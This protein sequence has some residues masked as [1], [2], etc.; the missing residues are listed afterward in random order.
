[1][2]AVTLLIAAVASAL[3][4][5]LSP[6]YGLVVYMTALIW[7]P[8]NL[9]VMLGPANF[10]VSRIVILALYL[11][12]FLKKDTLKRLELIW[13]DRLV[14]IYFAVRILSGIPTSPDITKVIEYNSGVFFDRALPYFAVRIIITNKEQYLLLLKWLLWLSAPLAVIAFYESLTG[15]NLVDFG[16][17]ITY[18]EHRWG[19]YRACATFPHPIRLGVFFAMIGAM[20]AGL[21]KNMKENRL[22][23]VIGIG[24]T[25]VGVFSSMSSGSLLAMIAAILFIA[26]YRFRRYW[27]AAIIGIILMCSVVEIVSNRHFYDVID[28]FAFNTSTAWYRTRLIEVALFEGGMRGHWLFGYGMAD[29]MWC[30]NID[31]RNHTDMV[32]QYLLVLCRFGLVG[33]IPFCAIIAVA[34]KKLFKNFWEVN[35]ESDIWLVWCLAA[36]LFGVLTAFNSVSLLSQP[37]TLFFMMLGLCVILPAKLA[38]RATCDVADNKVLV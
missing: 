17:N 18:G 34:I 20:C 10:S 22:F 11:S 31:M 1:M 7:Y 9:G 21:L 24:L 29:P 26:F 8:Q 15:H 13:L 6:F 2:E 16:R 32:N 3:I 36:A 30:E 4:F 37:L 19:L 27:K 38:G 5:F 33:F 28:Y 23:Y 12:I 14:L 35:S 25:V